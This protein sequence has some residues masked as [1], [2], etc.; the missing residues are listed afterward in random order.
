L[1]NV[2]SSKAPSGCSTLGTC[3]SETS[4]DTH[5]GRWT[6]IHKCARRASPDKTR[7]RQHENV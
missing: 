7:R 4:P 1:V 5:I 6:M 2:V 3:A